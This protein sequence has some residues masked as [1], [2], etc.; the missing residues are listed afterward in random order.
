MEKAR[1]ENAD[2]T[3]EKEKLEVRVKELEG[4]ITSLQAAKEEVPAENADMAKQAA[5]QAATIV[6][7]SRLSIHLITKFASRTLFERN[8]M[9]CWQRKKNG[10]KLLLRARLLL[11]LWITL[12][13]KKKRR[14]LSGRGM[15]LPR[16]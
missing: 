16:N 15:K 10:T 12:H 7:I 3:S 13:G 2:L 4:E 14:K 9:S 8:A 5:E 1:V 6:C 11:H